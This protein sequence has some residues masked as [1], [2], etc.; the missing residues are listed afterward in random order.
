M[1]KI[2]QIVRNYY[3]QLVWSFPTSEKIV[4]LTFDDGPTPEV[5][6]WVLDVLDTFDAKATFFLLGKN[7]EKHPEIA[8]RMIDSG[9]SIGNHGY[10]HIDGWKTSLRT[11]LRDFLKAQQSIYE[12]TGKYARLFRPAYAHIT[13]TKARYIKRSHQIIMMDVISGDFDEELS[14][15]DVVEAV[16][17]HVRP[18]SV[19]VFHDSEKAFPRLKKAL[20]E[21]LDR[22]QVGGYDFEAIPTRLRAMPG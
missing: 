8:H 12:Y 19:I 7:V 18:G 21:I 6:D 10:R 4:Y 20:P 17:S 13:Q 16:M 14:W 3:S 22:L 15:E 2:P 5:S 9:H 11:Y 1:K